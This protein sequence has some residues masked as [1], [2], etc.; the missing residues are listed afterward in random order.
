MRRFQLGFRYAH[1]FERRSEEPLIL[2]TQRRRLDA[3]LAEQ[4]ADA[5][6]DFR[7]GARAT[8]LELDDEGGVVRVGGAAAA[9]PVVI[10]ADGVNGL[11]ARTLGLDRPIVSTGSRSRATSLM[12]DA[13]EDYRGRAVV[14]LGAVP[15]GYGW[16][17]PKGDHVNVGVGGWEA[18]GPRLREHLE[19][20]VR[21]GTGSPAGRLETLRGHRL[22]MRAAGD[23]LCTRAACCSSAT[24]PGSSTR[25]PA[26]GCT[27]RSSAR[28]SPRRR[29]WTCSTGA[30]RRSRR[31][32]RGSTSA[33]GRTLARPGRRST[34]S[35]GSRALTSASRALPL[36]WRRRLARLVRGDV[37]HPGEA[38]GLV[39][40]P[41]ARWST[42]LGR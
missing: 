35:T 31:T 24:R 39:A 22:P 28:G 36:V 3:Y 26:T 15:G 19:R 5:G 13:R 17:F 32:R 7:D 9:A 34:R 14:E 38:T 37:A 18:E 30:R 2:M 10:G 8:A 11:T 40:R 25:S 23:P 21:A 29:R 12:F 6:A 42:R 16:V 33:L 4:A 41:A 20:A 27:R 1:R